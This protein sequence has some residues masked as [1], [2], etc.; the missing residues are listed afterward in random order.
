MT[1]ATTELTHT[2][3]LLLLEQQW[4]A[5]ME[6][7]Y[8]RAGDEVG[9][10]AGRFRQM[11]TRRGGLGTARQLLRVKVTSDGY[12]R[13]RAVDRLDLTVEAYMLRPEFAPLF[14]E[15]ELDAARGRLA[16]Y[17]RVAE[18]EAQAAEPAPAELTH[19]LADAATAAPDRRH[20]FRD[21]VAAFGP[22]AIPALETWVAEGNSAAFAYKVLETMGQHSDPIL[23]S[24]ALRRLK[25]SHPEL[26]DLI[27][28]ALVNLKG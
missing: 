11:L 22:R 3:T 20:E 7:S 2:E 27:D 25:T 9:Y 19:L 21:R 16:F 23:A 4:D 6:E 18:V 17:Q 26:A 24:D 10:W 12:A 13:L 14:T 8:Q 1:T 5:A 28:L 15:A